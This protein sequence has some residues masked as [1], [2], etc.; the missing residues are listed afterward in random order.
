MWSI[1]TISPTFAALT[2]ALL[3]GASMPIAKELVGQVSP[4]LLA[5]LLYVGSGVGLIVIRLIKDRGWNH[6]DLVKKD[7]LWL[8]GA[9]IFGG[10]LGPILLMAGLQQT[11]AARASLLLNLETVLT[12]FLAWII[13]KEHTAFRIML[14]MLLIVAGGILLS[15]PS[16]GITE[17]HNS[18]GP[19]AIAGACLCWAIDNN[20][21]RNISASD[22]LFIAGGKGLTAGIVNT[23]LALLLG[24]NLPN[25]QTIGYALSVGFIGYGA[26]LV[27]FVLALRGLGTVRTG[28]YFSTAPFI[29]AATAILFFQDKPSLVFWAATLLMGIGVWLHLTE[30]HEHE[31]RHEPFSHSHRHTHDEHHLHTHHFDWDGKEPHAHAHHHEP[32]THS[33]PHSP[34]IHHRHHHK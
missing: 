27:L 24:I 18:L 16:H 3:F 29:G 23:S 32:L 30:H 2:A 9:I 10:V 12:A 25:W 19:I 33:H 13:F 15:W 31:H 21:T 6:S 8:T 14:G 17:Q 1:R 7:W 5:G 28:A 4:I 22:P 26:S 34:D 20:F 11:G